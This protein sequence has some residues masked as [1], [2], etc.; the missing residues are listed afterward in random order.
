MAGLNRPRSR[1]NAV[2]LPD[3][4]VLVTG[5]YSS[6][7]SCSTG[8]ECPE[9]QA[10]LYENGSWRLLPAETSPRTYH[11]VSILLP[12]G[13]VLTGG[14]DTRTWDYPVFSPAYL[15]KP[16]R[17]VWVSWPTTE[18]AYDAPYSATFE[19]LPLGVEIEKVVLIAPGSTTHYSDMHQRYVSLEVETS[20]GDAVTFRTP[21]NRTYAP[22]GW[23][24]LFLVTNSKL[25]SE[26]KFV[27][28]AGNP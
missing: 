14:G 19:L 3:A 17:P 11:S 24:M 5:G 9:L 21:K 13:K 22:R 7:N 15:F 4:T 12:S 25:P 28:L 10:E 27:R 8:S 2:I 23:Y 18:L 6:P 1:L 16:N 26:G 20:E